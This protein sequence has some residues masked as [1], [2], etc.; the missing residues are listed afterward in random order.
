MR[1]SGRGHVNTQDDLS[2]SL[3]RKFEDKTARIGVIGLGYVGL[4]LALTF[5][6]AGFRVTGFDT[7]ATKIVS[8]MAGRSYI[9]HIPPSRIASRVLEGSLRATADFAGL[10][11]QDAILI[12]VPTPLTKQR[13]PDMR[14]VLVT[15]ETIARHLKR[16]QL[17]V[18]ESTT[19]PGTT[20]ELVQQALDE[21]GLRLGTDYLLAFSPEREDPGNRSFDTKN[22]PK[23]VGG[24]DA[25]SGHA[26]EKL[27]AAALASV[28]RVADARTAEAA[29]LTEN[30]FRGVN[31]ALVN[32]LKIVFDRMGIDIWKVLDAAE[33][34][35]FG[36]MRF[37]PGP[38]WGG[39]CIPIDPFYMAWKAREF[40]VATK[41][42]EL[43]GEIN[44]RM[45]EYVIGKLQTA[46]NEHGKPVKES[47]VLVLGVAYKADIDDCRESP[48]FPIME[49][50]LTLGASVQFHDP[51]VS[52]LP[53]TRGWPDF[54]NMTSQALT[55]T[56]VGSCDAVLLVTAHR[57]VDYELV[58]RNARLI[59]DTRR[60]FEP[61]SRVVQA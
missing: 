1:C 58:R 29:K 5:V 21:S 38:G 8:L 35:P 28:V 23:L 24:V 19:Y 50:L 44:V 52:A 14:Y 9:H 31:I 4:P 10:S 59:I 40:D 18:L 36:F 12:C 51:Y 26:A 7:D 61:S 16:G 49:K 3:A 46:L 15:S 53:R 41:F 47:R 60:V 20:D 13:E 30:I 34:K 32:E 42:I 17:V 55:E 25:A 39:H 6:E 22:I 33:T 11:D 37:N 57:A 48:A 45:P 27:Y 43:A 56:L 54:E 2:E